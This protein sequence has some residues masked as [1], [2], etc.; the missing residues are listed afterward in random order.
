MDIS[1]WMQLTLFL[2]ILTLLTKPVGIYLHSILNAEGKTFIDPV[3]K[4]FEQFLYRLL[5]TDIKKEQGW[6]QYTLSLCVFSLVSMLFTYAILRL[7]HLLPLN[8]Q[9]AIHLCHSSPAAS[10]TTQSPEVW[11]NKSTSGVQYGSQ[12]CHQYQLAKLRR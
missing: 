12:F 4:P 1:G 3:I 2:S 6:K 5:R 7:Q 8:P 9:F 11:A 10:F